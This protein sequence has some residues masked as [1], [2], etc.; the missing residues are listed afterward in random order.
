MQY[1]MESSV[2]TKWLVEE[3]RS[4]LPNG[5]QL[6]P[7]TASRESCAA[8]SVATGPGKQ[9]VAF[10]IVEQLHGTVAPLF[11]LNS[12]L[13]DWGHKTVFLFVGDP[14]PSTATMPCVQVSTDQ[15]G[16][17]VAIVNSGTTPDRDRRVYTD[18]PS[19]VAAAVD[20]RLKPLTIRNGM[21][22]HVAAKLSLGICPHCGRRGVGIN[23]VTVRLRETPES[24]PLH[25]HKLQLRRAFSSQ[26]LALVQPHSNP[27]SDPMI[28]DNSCSA[29]LATAPSF[30]YHSTVEGVVTLSGYSV[31]ELLQHHRTEW[32]IEDAAASS[33]RPMTQTAQPW[34]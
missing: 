31:L 18:I 16:T 2:K 28:R 1:A 27:E 5:W 13:R 8:V 19:L 7:N 9:R 6:N 25:L 17:R 22:I 3:L 20:S 33:A 26:V 15:D 21:P 30:D 34:A 32:Y 23:S 24:Q 4:A 14:I 29:C 10:A 12:M 11:K